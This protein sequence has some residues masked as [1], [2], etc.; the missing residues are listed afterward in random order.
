MSAR[1]GIDF[2]T[3]NTVVAVWDSARG[4]GTPLAVP[5]YGRLVWM[6]KE[7]L[8][9]IPSLVHLAPG[10]RRWI[11]EQ[12]L[13]QNLVESP[14]TFRWMKRFISH[15]SASR[16]KVDGRDVSHADAGQ[17]FLSAVL[18]AALSWYSEG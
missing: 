11:G 18:R 4:E 14:R 9:L 13:E 8:S 12:V 2:G 15:R 16:I 17:E 1:L 7:A 3:S 5:G 10:R 6:G